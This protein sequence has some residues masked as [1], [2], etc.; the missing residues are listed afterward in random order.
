MT[1]LVTGGAGF[2]GSNFVCYW[3]SRHPN[4][5]IIV[6]DKLTYA[7]NLENLAGVNEQI[8]FLKG[9]I[10]D[11]KFVNSAMDGVHTVVHFAA[12]SHNDRAI[13]EPDIFLQ[14]NIVGTHVLLKAALKFKINHFHHISTD[15]VFGSIS[16]D[17]KQKWT[18]QS[19]YDPRSP[20]S[21]SKASSDHLV[22]AY[23]HTYGLPITITNCTNNFGPKQFPEKLISLAITNLLQ[24]KKV[25]IYGAGNQVRDW[26]YVDDHNKAVEIVLAKG[27]IGQTYLVGSSHREYTNLEVVKKIIQILGKS[28][29]QIE[30]VV[31]RKGHDVKYAI[32]CSKIK[33]QLGW[34]PEHDFETSL[35]KTVSWYEK[36]ESWWKHVQSGN[37]RKF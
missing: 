37:Y 19:P 15:E 17:S 22:R 25:L 4:D 10:C 9:D 32:D 30:F 7:G 20:Y 28:E 3:A 5:K 11:E 26:L 31:D 1:I 8:T 14:T 12:E 24:E 34:K 23:F 2:I 21:A 33:D 18:E 36:N 27:E 35:Q 16:L 13:L 6:I 29:E